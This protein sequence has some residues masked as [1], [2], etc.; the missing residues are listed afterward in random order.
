MN[1][2]EYYTAEEKLSMMDTYHGEYFPHLYL[3]QKDAE[4]NLSY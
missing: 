2:D 1:I 4:N 3:S